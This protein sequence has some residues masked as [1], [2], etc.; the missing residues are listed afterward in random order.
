M[1][2]GGAAEAGIVGGGAREGPIADAAGDAAVRTSAPSIRRDGRRR[3]PSEEEGGPRSL[4]LPLLPEAGNN[5]IRCD[6]N[7]NN[8]QNVVFCLCNEMFCVK[9]KPRNFYY[10]LVCWL[11]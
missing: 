10:D 3:D 5:S 7:S 9:K 2:G 4:T 11:L 6:R 1:P 8:T